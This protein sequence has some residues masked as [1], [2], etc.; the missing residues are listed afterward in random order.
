MAKANRVPTTEPSDETSIVVSY[1]I[2]EEEI[3]KTFASYAALGF[4]NPERYEDG[5]KALAHLRRT[6]VDIDDRRKFLNRDALAYQRKVN[7]EAKKFTGLISE[8]ED[9]LQAKK[10]AADASKEEQR[11]AAEDAEREA[12]RLAEQAKLDAQRTE[13]ERIETEQK[14]IREAEAAKQ[15][16][17]RQRLEADRAAQAADR[18]ALE[19]D[20]EAMRLEREEIAA[21][22][23]VVEPVAYVHPLASSP[24]EI[25]PAD[26]EPAPVAAPAPP[27]DWVTGES[28]DSARLR[29]FAGALRNLPRPAVDSDTAA[30]VLEQVEFILGEAVQALEGFGEVKE[31]ATAAE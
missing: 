29:A 26:S 22:R 2:T 19:A 7:A 5:R 27:I 3:K 10:D 15:A 24:A 17:E 14:A 21:A 4:E 20:R 13:L 9:P 28:Q 12:M 16:E 31:A 30:A 25:L 18:A 11:R 6:R 8:I 23:R 1:A